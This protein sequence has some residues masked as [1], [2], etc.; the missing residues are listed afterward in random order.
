MTMEYLRY[1]ASAVV[2]AI[3]NRWTFLRGY[4]YRRILIVRLDH[5]GDIVWC[6]ESIRALRRCFPEAT[7]TALI[8]EWNAGILKESPDVSD[9]LVYNSPVF[10][11]DRTRVTSRGERLRLLG[12]LRNRHFDLIVGFRDDAFTIGASVLLRPRIR[13]DRG[14]VRIRKK[15]SLSGAPLGPHEAETNHAVV[16]PVLRER[17][18]LAADTGSLIA[19][20]PDEQAWLDDYLQSRGIGRRGYAVLHPGASWVYR[21]WKP[22]NFSAVADFL[23]T[24]FGLT[25]VVIGTPEESDVSVQVIGGRPDRFVNAT[26]ESTLRQMMLLLSGARI[27]VCNDSGPAHVAAL[28]NTP[29]VVLLGPNDVARFAPRGKTIICFHKKLEC[30]PCAQITCKYS[31]NPCVN[32]TSVEEVVRVIPSL[33]GG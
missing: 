28:L 1:I 12:A 10:T 11:R 15:F 6:L 19:F 20:S 3:V 29:A 23:Y 9:I 27:A 14:T 22:S 30:N 33:I 24:R 26:G 31:Q 32:L 5:L 16:E 8:G 21:R 18:S 7:I 17:P 25:S 4:D 13:V 2:S